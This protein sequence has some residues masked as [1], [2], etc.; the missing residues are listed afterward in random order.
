MYKRIKTKIEHATT[1][2]RLDDDGNILSY[3]ISPNEGYKLH[4]ITL[5]EPDVDENGNETGEIRLGFTESYVTAGADYD[6][7]KNEREIYV[8]EVVEGEN[9]S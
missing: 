3:R 8:L 1:K 9:D 2:A 5:D 6:F 4:E 7:E